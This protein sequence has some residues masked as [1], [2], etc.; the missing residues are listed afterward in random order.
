[1]DFATRFD[2]K[3]AE[4]RLYQYWEKAGL[5]TPSAESS[6]E[7]FTIVIPPPN[8]TGS[9]HIGHALNNTLQDILIRVKRMQGYEALYLPGTDHAGIATQTV[10][11]RELREKERKTRWEIGREEFLKRVWAWKEQS[12]NTIL[13][14]LR[15]LGC[16]CDWTRTRFTMDDGYSRAVRHVFVSLF[17]KG[18][19]YRGLAIVNWCPK[20]K[21]ALSD[22]EVNSPDD[23]PPGKL[24]HINYPV[25]DQPGRFL[26]VA[27]TRPETMLGDTAVAVHPDDPRYKALIGKTVIL[28]L[29]DREIPVIG[30]G[31]LVD[32]KFG[33]GV[34]KVTPAHDPNDFE[35]GK[36]NKLPAIIVMDE[37]AVINDKGGPY[38]GLDRYEARKRIVADLEAKGLLVKTEDHNVPAGTCYRCDTVVEPYLSEQWFCSMKKLAAPA[39]GAVKSGEI[40]FH[41]ER[42]TKLYLDWMENI[43]D[44][45]I[46]RQIW[47]GHR[48][49]VWYCANKHAIAS[50][51][52]PTSCPQCGSKELR[53]DNDVLDTWF[54]SALWPFATLGW[55]EETP[56]LE[57]FYPTQVLV[58]GRD[59]INLWVARMIVSGFEFRGEKPFTDVVIN[60]TILDDKGERMSKVKRNGVD[61]L[62]LI[63]EFG[64]DA[65]R[66]AMAWVT[67]GTQ[68]VRFGKKLSRQRTEMSRNFVTK[69]WNA[70][71]YSAEKIGDL[72]FEAPATAPTD[73]LQDE[74]RWIFSRLS[75]TVDGVTSAIDRYEF[76]EAAQLLYKFVWDD[77][78]AWYLELSKRRA[79]EQ[80]VRRTLATVLDTTLRLMHPFTPFFTEEIW[81]K[82]GRKQS[83][84]T[85][86]WPEATEKLRNPDLEERMALVFECVGVIREVRNRNTISPKVALSVVI[87]AKDDF[88]AQLLKAGAEIIRDQA[89]VDELSIGVNVAKPKFSATGA[90]TRFSAYV[91]LEGKI[92][93][94]AEGGRTEKE[95]EKTR[96]QIAQAEKQLSNEEFR[97]RKPEM[98]KEVEEKL[99]ALRAKLSELEAHLKEIQSG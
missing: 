24:W 31:I 43:R 59:I 88:T 85:A 86:P 71:R 99:A 69:L 63:E 28:P 30:D 37:S 18:L 72:P 74:D 95:I 8:V 67:T 22:L 12:G 76:G 4:A 13:T 1:M 7:P 55:P 36:R 98:A 10:V 21:T 9:L 32:P 34:V 51:E 87:S 60:A 90:A 66:F 57:K 20:D 49:P 5:F 54:S 26:T 44:W 46:S 93:V 80:P 38:Q 6:R 39:I 92:D 47:W 96:E 58:T 35:S 65:L 56:D 14:Q 77:F 17:K 91:P 64:A 79:T 41:P 53:Q 52:D 29:L 19:I 25:K 83:I 45:C 2:P 68:D 11:E 15:R 62:E 81:Q 61:P 16:S 84:M 94:K 40:A 42:W 3:E 78:C 89:N 48:I 73:G 27:T 75:T 70:A 50:V 97:K 33:S 82:L 23:A